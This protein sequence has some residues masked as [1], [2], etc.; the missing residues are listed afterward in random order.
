MAELGQGMRRGSKRGLIKAQ[1]PMV[2]EARGDAESSA[3]LTFLTWPTEGLR[4]EY[5]WWWRGSRER[6]V[7]RLSPERREFAKR[8]KSNDLRKT[9]FA[10]LRRCGQIGSSGN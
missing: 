6:Y 8:K 3:L 4:R 9:W 2:G 10:R 5:A 7:K 1:A